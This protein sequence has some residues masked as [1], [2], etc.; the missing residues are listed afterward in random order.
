MI[1]RWFWNT[2]KVLFIHAVISILI[3]FVNFFP[4]RELGV[5]LVIIK[6]IE[7]YRESKYMAKKM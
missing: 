6:L 7:L 3:M 2:H 5:Q 4:H 1:G